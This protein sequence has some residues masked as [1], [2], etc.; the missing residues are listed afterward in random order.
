MRLPVVHA[1]YQ[2]YW[3]EAPNGHGVDAL[4]AVFSFV[5]ALAAVG[6]LYLAW[7]TVREGAAARREDRHASD[8][9]RLEDLAELVGETGDAALKGMYG[10]HVH[11]N[12]ILPIQRAR[13]AAALALRAPAWTRVSELLAVGRMRPRGEAQTRGGELT[14]GPVTRSK[15]FSVRKHPNTAPWI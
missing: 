7:R 14:P 6:A 10:S 2:T 3:R 8:L 13:L 15:P 4:L 1:S 11:R 9:E 12:V 5:S